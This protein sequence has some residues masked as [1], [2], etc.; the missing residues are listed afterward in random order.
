MCRSRIAWENPLLIWDTIYNWNYAYN[1]KVKIS[2]LRIMC[3]VEQREQPFNTSIIY[4]SPFDLIQL[5]LICQ[6]LAKFLG[7]NKEN[8]IQVYK[9]KKNIFVLC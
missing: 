9:N 5:H 6:M 8:R 3:Y 1:I 7:L 2:R 4:R